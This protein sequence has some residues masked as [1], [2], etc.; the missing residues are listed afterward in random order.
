MK[1]ESLITY[2]S[3][4]MPNVKVFSKTK[5]KQ[6]IRTHRQVDKQTAKIIC[7]RSINVRKEKV[8]KSK[9]LIVTRIAHFPQ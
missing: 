6:D 7:P 1:Y 3:K 5:D 8:F 2:H 4:V 9:Q